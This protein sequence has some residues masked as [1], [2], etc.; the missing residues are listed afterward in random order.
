MCDRG[1]G[2]AGVDQGRIAMTKACGGSEDG[3]A[4]W[5]LDCEFQVEEHEMTLDFIVEVTQSLNSAP[6]AWTIVI[7]GV[8]AASTLGTE[9]ESTGC[10]VA[11]GEIEA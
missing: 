2:A 5:K 6:Y 8:D 10:V 11:V 9:V 3:G 7:V 4:A 1:T